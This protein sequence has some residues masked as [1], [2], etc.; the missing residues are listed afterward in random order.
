MRNIIIF[1]ILFLLPITGIHAQQALDDEEQF[2]DAEYFFATEEFGE[3]F[4]IF[5]QLLNKFPDNANLNF[6]AGMSLLSIEGREKEALPYFL[7]AVKKTTLKYKERDFSI[8]AAPHHAWFYL[9]NAYRINNE[10]DKALESYETFR[11]INKFE[12]KYNIGIVEKEVKACERAKIIKDNPVNLIKVNLGELINTGA[13]TYQPVVNADETVLCFMQEQKF[14]DAIMISY[15]KDGA[16]TQ[17]LNISPQIGSDGDMTPAAFSAD[18]SE[19][20]LVKRNNSSEG[21]IYYSRKTDVFW[22]KAV[23][24]GK[25]INT[26]SDEDHASFSSDGQSI[27]FSSARKGGQGGLDLYI[28]NR[29]SDGNW[30]TAINLGMIINSENDETSAFFTNKDSLLYFSS[31]G[32]FNMGGYD[33]FFSKKD[34]D[35]N[36]IDPANIGFPLNTTTDN[37]FFQPVNEA[38]IGY[39]ALFGE[40]SNFGVEDIYRVEILPFTD[41]QAP[42]NPLATK[43]FIMRLENSKSGEIIEIEYNRNTDSFKIKTPIGG[44]AEWS[45]KKE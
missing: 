13:K 26:M 45:I 22:S 9:G 42:E 32:H 36:W 5:N 43:D 40:E 8:T 3:A 44:N 10:L 20:L 28:S 23:K 24:L 25:T 4:F 21:D 41:P 33:I 19:M 31:K 11:D 27:I 12:K 38:N 35:G 39:I 15:K 37:T 7:K 18:G 29:L 14:Y 6:R 30:G 16:W 1:L 2:D 17:P 34:S